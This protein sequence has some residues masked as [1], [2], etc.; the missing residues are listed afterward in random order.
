MGFLFSFLRRNLFSIIMA[1]VTSLII[2]AEL[3]IE[4]SVYWSR[5]GISF[6]I[7]LSLF[8]L[9][10]EKHLLK[11]EKEILDTQKGWSQLLEILTLPAAASAIFVALVLFAQEIN[12]LPV[13]PFLICLG[14]VIS[15]SA[16]L[17]IR[18]LQFPACFRI[19]LMVLLYTVMI[20]YF[21]QNHILS[22]YIG[23]TT[24]GRSIFSPLSNRIHPW[25]Q[26]VGLLL[27]AA[28]FRLS[29]LRALI[30]VL[31]N[32]PLFFVS[33][34]TGSPLISDF[35]TLVMLTNLGGS[36]RVTTKV[37]L[38]GLCSVIFFVAAGF[39]AGWVADQSVTFAYAGTGHSLGMGHPNLAALILLSIL[40]LIWYLWLKDHPVLTA[41]ISIPLAM[42]VYLIT[43]SRTGAICIALLPFFCLYRTFLLKKKWNKGFAVPILSPVV[44]AG[45]SIDAI[46]AVPKSPVQEGHTFIIRFF[47]SFWM[48]E[49]HG[50]TFFGL[51][52]S[53]YN[54]HV[55]DNLFCHSLIY[56]GLFSLALI[57]IILVWIAWKY[58]RQHQYAELMMLSIF[59]IY[60]VMEN[61][62]LYMPY[63]FVLLL[64]ASRGQWHSKCDSARTS[65][66]QPSL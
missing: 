12:L 33:S 46:F 50:L 6:V 49:K 43:Y 63:G 39:A 48:L 24:E 47:D 62:L 61:A 57:F 13:N 15:I 10:S 51:P 16:A 55:L 20:L 60:S 3:Y 41:V 37:V 65:T 32:I 18:N 64:L 21:Y 5:A 4:S 58:Y 35:F 45:F 36:P 17:I 25:L 7:L 27:V 44:A 53:Q 1:A 14:L 66:L 19:M 59:I 40:M 26:I 11:K 22:G 8:L 31:V 52:K 38:A 56:Y 9:L 29:P 23:W 42:G 34:N 28:Q 54:Y 30:T 2:S